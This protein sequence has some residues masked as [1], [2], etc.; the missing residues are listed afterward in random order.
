[1]NSRMRRTAASGLTLWSM[2]A[3]AALAQRRTPTLISPDGSDEDGWVA[4]GCPTFSWTLVAEATGYELRIYEAGSQEE[5]PAPSALPRLRKEFPDGATSWTPPLRDCLPPGRYGWAVAAI[6][7]EGEPRWSRPGLFEVAARPPHTPA[8]PERREAA[9]LVTTGPPSSATQAWLSPGS[10]LEHF[11]DEAYTPP[12]CG[13][14]K[15]ADVPAG[16]PFCRWIEQLDRDGIMSSCDGGTNFCPDNPVTRKQLAMALGKTARGTA[17]WHPAQGSNWLAP[18]VGNIVTTV[19]DVGDV[20]QYSSITIGVDGLP[21]ISYY[22]ATAV[23]SKVV[24]CNDVACAPGGETVTTLN[25]FWFFTG[26]YSSITIGADGLP[27]ISYYSA[28]QQGV[29]VV[30]CNDLACTGQDETIT[31]VD[32]PDGLNVGLYTSIAIGADGLALIS[33]YDATNGDLKVVHCTNPACTNHD[34][35]VALATTGDV[36][37]YTAITIGADG[38]G[39]IVSSPVTILAAHCANVTCT[40]APSAPIHDLGQY[41]SITIGTDGLGLIA[42]GDGNLRVLHCADVACTGWDE[43]AGLDPGSAAKF[44]STTIGAD[45]LGLISYYGD[46][47]DDLKVAHCLNTKCTAA[48]I[49]PL[50]TAGDVG[51]YSAITIGV[52]GL[53][54]VSYYDATNGALKVAH[55]S[56]VFCAPYFRRR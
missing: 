24:H 53:P 3:I 36:G 8:A 41:L 21:I 37:Q 35:P 10:N 27:I 13:S 33:Y 22:D 38:L 48:T 19:D 14:G 34:P 54:I 16:S 1:M 28:E 31:A 23:R 18:P 2:M 4:T 42:F 56:N 9:P 46:A 29:R 43:L 7:G 26:Q 51:Q 39:L 25:D 50:D 45:S 17:T 47:S 44:T 15:F 30:H 40:S 55:C 52:D 5:I 12:L 49:T 6:V 20:G 11:G 32:A